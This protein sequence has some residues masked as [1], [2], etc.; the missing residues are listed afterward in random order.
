[1]RTQTGQAPEILAETIKKRRRESHEGMRCEMPGMRNGE[2]E[3]L[4]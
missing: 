3:S 4:P 2:Q 1:M